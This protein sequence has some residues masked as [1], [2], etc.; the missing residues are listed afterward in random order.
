MYGNESKLQIT[1]TTFEMVLVLASKMNFTPVWNTQQSISLGRFNKLK[2]TWSGMIAGVI[3]GSV[4]I[5]ANGYWKTQ[6]RMN[7]VDFTFPVYNCYAL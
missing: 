4:E 1:G 6:E 5:A 7:A 3:N 2:N